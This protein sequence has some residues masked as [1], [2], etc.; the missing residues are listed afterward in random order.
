MDRR[1][2]Y[3]AHSGLYISALSDYDEDYVYSY[4]KEFEKN[5]NNY[6][7]IDKIIEMF[8]ASTVYSLNQSSFDRIKRSTEFLLENPPDL[9]DV[10]YLNEA[11]AYLFGLPEDQDALKYLFN[12]VYDEFF[13][14]GDVPLSVKDK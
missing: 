1:D 10:D 3:S 5:H 9:E 6:E 2:A 8:V 4:F 12:R 14:D 11:A 7:I 13:K